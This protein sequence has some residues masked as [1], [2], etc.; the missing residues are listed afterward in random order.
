MI[1]PEFMSIVRNDFAGHEK[2]R[3]Q[4]L[5]NCPHY[6]NNDDKADRWAVAVSNIL[7][8]V[9]E[10]IEQPPEYVLA[11]ALYSLHL[12]FQMGV[13]FP[14]TPDGRRK[15]EF[16]SEN[17]SPTH[18]ADRSGLTALLQS[19]AKLPNWRTLEGGLGI[20]L[21][22]K[23]EPEHFISTMDTFFEMGGQHLGVTV[24]DR[25]TLL[26][27]RDHP[28]NYTDL[29]VRITGFSAYFNTL[30]PDGKEDIIK[31]TDY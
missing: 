10:E 9:A 21:S 7:F 18:G 4:I 16:I 6:G 30:S 31:R 26:D 22:G 25:E 19:A 14:A 28:E 15:G 3:Q 29:C 1:L 12:H 13:N 24:M 17:Q 8:D 2:L 11:P 20:R 27:A 5:N 23:V